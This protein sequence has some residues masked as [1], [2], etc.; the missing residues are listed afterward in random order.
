MNLLNHDEERAKEKEF[1]SLHKG[2]TQ[3]DERYATTIEE[4]EKVLV[5]C[6]KNGFDGELKTFPSKEN[7]KLLFCSIS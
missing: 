7:V 1:V 6:F 2:T 4:K 3:V 5:T